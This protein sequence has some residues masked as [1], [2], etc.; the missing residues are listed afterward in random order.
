LQR[1]KSFQE[2]EQEDSDFDSLEN[3]ITV[4][5][6]PPLEA[7]VKALEKIIVSRALSKTKNTRKAALLLGVSQSTI[8]R[9]IKDYAIPQNH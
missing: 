6:I 2:K 3:E 1:H 8:M 9:K 4:K 5:G 7:S